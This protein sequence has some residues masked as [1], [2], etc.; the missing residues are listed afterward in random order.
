MEQDPLCPPILVALP[1]G[2]PRPDFGPHADFIQ[3]L[4]GTRLSHAGVKAAIEQA[5]TRRGTAFMHRLAALAGAGPV[6]PRPDIAWLRQTFAAVNKIHGSASVALN[7]LLDDEAGAGA[8]QIALLSSTV[9][10]SAALRRDLLEQINRATDPEAPDLAPSGDI[11]IAALLELVVRE[12]RPEAESRG[13]HLQ[14]LKPDLPLTFRTV[15]TR[16]R[17]ALR[18]LLR[19]TIRNSRQGAVVDVSLSV[20]EGTV[21]V[22]IA[23][24]GASGPWAWDFA[25]DTVMADGSA[26]PFFEKAGSMILIDQFM[27]ACNGSVDLDRSECRPAVLRCFFPLRGAA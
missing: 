4:D 16:L 6:A 7:G 1:A 26:A 21:C 12:Y 5:M 15:P 13:Q 25:D 18:L 27:R 2:R 17:D 23:D 9:E 10:T 8:G 19:N 11:D 20:R 22:S 14:F 24:R 3:V